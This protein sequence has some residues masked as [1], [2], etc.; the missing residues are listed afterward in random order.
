[1]T[2]ASASGPKISPQSTSWRWD[3]RKLTAQGAPLG[4]RRRRT[5]KMGVSMRELIG[6]LKATLGAT[7]V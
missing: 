7:S 6:A 5:A 1:M 2:H 4:T 3:I